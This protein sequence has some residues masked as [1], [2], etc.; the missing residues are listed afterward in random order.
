MP[1]ADARLL[2]NHADGVMLVV[3]AAYA[4]YETVEQ[5][6]EALSSHRLIGAVLNG[7]ENLRETRYYSEYLDYSKDHSEGHN[8]FGWQNIA[9]RFRDSWLGKRL[10]L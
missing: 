1:F 8:G 6:T 2:A 10:K 5:A 9:P 4:P 3:R 7:A